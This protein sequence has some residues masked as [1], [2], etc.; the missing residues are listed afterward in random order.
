MVL[1]EQGLRDTITSLGGI[2]TR[3]SRQRAQA[4]ADEAHAQQRLIDVR[5]IEGFVK[6]ELEDLQRRLAEIEAQK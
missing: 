3:L 5:A 2:A 6:I 1:N 4:E